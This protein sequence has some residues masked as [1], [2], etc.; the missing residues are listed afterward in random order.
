M[1][2]DT[3]K[4]RNDNQVWSLYLVRTR[5]NT[6]YTGIALDVERRFAEHAGTGNTGSKYLRSKGPLELVYQAEIGGRALALQ[7]EYRV[8]QL[9][10]TRKEAIIARNLSGR[11]LLSDLNLQD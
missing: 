11:A 9:P 2:S 1:D 4:T 5:M 8:K 6:L 3:Q 7:A 10:R